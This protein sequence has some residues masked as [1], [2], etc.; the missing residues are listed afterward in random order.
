VVIA[1]MRL[2]GGASGVDAVRALRAQYGA[3]LPG[4]LVT[5]ETGRDRVAEAIASGIPILRKPVPPARLIE[6]ID[7][8]STRT[9]V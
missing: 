3:D 7:R 2:A 6:E 4:L 9:R 1:D 5:G 8:L